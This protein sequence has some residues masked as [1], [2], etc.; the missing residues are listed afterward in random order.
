MVFSSILFLF[1]F[2]PAFFLVYYLVPNKFRNFICLIGSLIF[3]AWGEPYYVFLMLLSI[4]MNYFLGR[5]LRFDRADRAR[6]RVM[7]LACVVNLAMLFVFKYLTFFLQTAYDLFG[8]QKQAISLPLPL[9]ISFYTFQALSYILDVYRKR[10]PVQTRFLNLAL[11]ICMFPQ[12]VAGPIVRYADIDAQINDR[13]LELSGITAGITRFTVG[14]GKKVLLANVLGSLADAVWKTPGLEISALTA[15]LGI[16]AYTLQIYFDFSGYSDMAIGL[17]RMMGFRFSENFNYPYIAASVSEFWRRWHISLSSWFRDYVYFPLGGSR[18]TRTKTV[19]NLLIVWGLTGF[20][21]GANWTFLL[22]GL[23]FGVLICFEKMSTKREQMSPPP[24]IYRRLGCLLAVMLGWVLFRSDSIAE[25][26]AYLLR[27]FGIGGQGVL[28]ATA[29]LYLHDNLLLIVAACLG[30]TPLIKRIADR[31]TATLPGTVTELLRCCVV[32]L[33]LALCT[34]YLV[35][36][37]YNPFI[38]FR[39]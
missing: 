11:Y 7:L 22:W 33:L 18:T 30:S 12:L 24:R 31:L 15:W 29:R 35:N 38:Y 14:L 28:D 5:L 20:W 17:G 16:I 26:G 21:H 3:Y 23:Y 1:Y 6:K 25:A 34:L 8:I 2:V 9:G 36:S 27:L 39:F 32:L 13:K 37:T 4:A 19:R 10:V